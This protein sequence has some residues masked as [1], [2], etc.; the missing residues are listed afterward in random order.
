MVFEPNAIV[1]DYLSTNHGIDIETNE[2]VV[3]ITF[4]LEQHNFK[5]SNLVISRS[6]AQRL[7]ADLSANLGENNGCS[8]NG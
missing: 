3:A 4:R 8:V 5:P 2:P 6:Q 1:V 7:L